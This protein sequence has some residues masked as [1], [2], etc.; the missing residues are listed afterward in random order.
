M[1]IS[2]D[3]N[4]G[5]SN[6][7]VGLCLINTGEMILLKRIDA[8][9]EHRVDP[10][11]TLTEVA[12]GWR[13]LYNISQGPSNIP[14]LFYPQYGPACYLPQTRVLAFQITV[15]GTEKEVVM[16]VLRASPQERFWKERWGVQIEGCLSVG[17]RKEEGAHGLCL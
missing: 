9:L 3:K 2:R 5:F 8:V 11:H 13:R 17:I 6:G 7:K 12:H 14:I 10:D 15:R 16:N 1:T 4:S